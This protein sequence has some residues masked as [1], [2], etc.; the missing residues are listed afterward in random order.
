MADARPAPKIVLPPLTPEEQEQ[1]RIALEAA[2]EY[3]ERILAE[4]GGVPFPNSWEEFPSLYEPDDA[5]YEPDN[6][7]IEQMSVR[8]GDMPLVQGRNQVKQRLTDEERDRGL[9]ALADLERFGAKLLLARDGKLFPNSWQE[10]DMYAADDIGD[11][12]VPSS[13]DDV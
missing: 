12:A 4:R 6:E 5:D 10:F 11:V 3:R 7:G 13:R 9:Q 2:R 1:G 8:G